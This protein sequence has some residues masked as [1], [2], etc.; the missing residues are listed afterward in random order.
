ME[1]ENGDKIALVSCSDPLPDSCRKQIDSLVQILGQMGL[2][3]VLSRYLYESDWNTEGTDGKKEENGLSD[4]LQPK[5]YR[6]GKK[7]AEI[8]MEFY[9]DEE[10]K[11][12]FD[13]SGGDMANEL[14]SFLDYELIGKSRKQFWGYSDLT[15]VINAVYAKTGNASVLYQVRNLVQSF[16]EVQQED[17]YSSLIEGSSQ[18]F[19]FDYEFWQGKEVCGIVVG[20]NIRCLL[21]LAGTPYWPDMNGK[22]L[23][24]EARSGKMPQLITFF[25]QLHQMGVFDQIQGLILGTF[26]QFEREENET[27][28][29]TLVQRFICPELPVIRTGRIGHGSDSKALVIGAMH[30]FMK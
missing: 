23:F 30:C 11:V 15:V 10:I 19:S 27:E 16:W 20:G 22:I 9:R 26:T 1:L 6:D 29:L 13:V 28:L 8:L 5:V 12:I 21:K 18:L 25:G 24:L 14:L 4:K 17:F 2:V 3:P 7:C